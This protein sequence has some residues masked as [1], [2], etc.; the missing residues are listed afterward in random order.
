MVLRNQQTDALVFLYVVFQMRTTWGQHFQQLPKS[1]GNARF[2][3]MQFPS[4]SCKKAAKYEISQLFLVDLKGFEPS[5]SRM[6]TERSAAWRTFS[7][8]NYSRTKSKKAYKN[9]TTVKNGVYSWAEEALPS[10]KHRAEVL[11]SCNDTK[12]MWRSTG[13]YRVRYAP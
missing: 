1:A 5:I 10:C 3:S 11:S 13:A 4:N 6:R 7:R 12:I 2:A 8:R 9:M